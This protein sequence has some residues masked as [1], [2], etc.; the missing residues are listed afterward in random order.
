MWGRRLLGGPA[1]C[2]LGG[3]CR[4]VPWPGIVRRSGLAGIVRPGSLEVPL[5]AGKQVGLCDAF[6]QPAAAVD[7]HLDAYR[8]RGPVALHAGSESLGYQGPKG[9]PFGQGLLAGLGE[10]CVW[11][12]DGGTHAQERIHGN[13]NVCRLP[14]FR[15]RGS[16]VRVEF[17][18]LTA[19]FATRTRTTADVPVVSLQRDHERNSQAPASPR[20]PLHGTLWP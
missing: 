12:V 10:Q 9:G 20:R 7:L 1:E 15:R 6:G 16:G 14:P 4:T 2:G 3:Y 8:P 11:E 18:A 5:L 19:G 17:P 13:V